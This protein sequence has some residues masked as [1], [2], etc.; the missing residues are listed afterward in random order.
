M[1]KTKTAAL[2]LLVASTLA[3]PSVGQ[4]QDSNSVRVSYA[5]LNLASKPAQDTLQRRIVGAAKVVCV[6]EDS[7]EMALARATNTCRAG[8]VASAQPAYQA[9]VAAAR[10]GSVTVLDAAALIVSNH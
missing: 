4:A 3:L 8:A 5:D 1:F 9:A 2:S 10:K 7:R 6:I